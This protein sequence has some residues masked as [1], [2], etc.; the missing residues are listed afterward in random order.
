M[1][2][3]KL[4]ARISIDPAICHGRACILGTRIMVSIILDCLATG[5]PE[6][7][8]LDEYPTLSRED[9]RAALAHAASGAMVNERRPVPPPRPVPAARPPPPPRPQHDTEK[10]SWD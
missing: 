5:M 6:D 4:L 2:K 8:I 7:E 1:T 9:I 3:Q 10:K